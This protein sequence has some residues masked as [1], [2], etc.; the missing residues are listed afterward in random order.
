MLKLS[1]QPIVEN[2]IY[3]GVLNKEGLGTIKVTGRRQD[4]HLE[5]VVSDDGIGINPEAQE[6]LLKPKQD[7]VTEETKHSEKIALWN[8]DQRIRKQY[9]PDYGLT[10]SSLPGQGT[11]VVIIFPILEVTE[12]ND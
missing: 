9:G 1:L 5:I 4:D 6:G 10:I 12:S 7:D 2:C 8:I 11:Q 3:H